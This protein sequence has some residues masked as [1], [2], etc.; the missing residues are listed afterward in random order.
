MLRRWSAAKRQ[1]NQP[2]TGEAW[3]NEYPSDV[4]TPHDDGLGSLQILHLPP[5]S[6]L[7]LHPRPDAELVTY[8]RQGAVAYEDSLG[9]LDIIRAGEFS[10]MT[11]GPGIR[12]TETN[13]SQTE[14]AHVFRICL[15]STAAPIE[16]VCERKRFTVAERRGKLCVVGSPDGREGSLRIRR[17]ALIYS[18]IFSGGQHVVHELPPGRC[19]WLC[20]VSGEMALGDLVLTKS[21]GVSVEN[22]RAVSITT[23]EDSEVLLLLHEQPE[24]PF[25]A[26]D[27]EP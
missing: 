19:A 18:A 16:P 6:A 24:R 27:R 21:D 3:I 9:R 11:G 20:M 7:P 4:S 25:V 1:P 5:G 15:G 17:D 23:R 8:V 22:E 26:Q 12:W 10:R 14:W 2:H 13:A